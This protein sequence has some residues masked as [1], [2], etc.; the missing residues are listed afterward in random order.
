MSLGAIIRSRLTTDAPVVTLNDRRVWPLVV[1]QRVQSGS[2]IVYQ[3]VSTVDIDGD[4]RLRET[5]LQ[6]RCWHE[7]YDDAHAL[8]A[9]VE[10]ALIGFADKDQS[11]QLL[12]TEL[13]NK[14][15]D[16]EDDGE[17]YAVVVDFTLFY[18]D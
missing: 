3:V 8:A 13:L 6:V 9:A 18:S 16:Y 17:R 15:D 5:R 4:N 10:S 2:G 11:P 1:P 12:C 14:I 7:T